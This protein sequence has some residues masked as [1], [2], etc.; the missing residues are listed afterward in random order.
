M[1]DDKTK[2]LIEKLE[3]GVMDL[4]SSDKY[5]G[6]LKTMS[7]FYNYSY[8]NSLLIALQNPS[9]TYVAGFNSWRNN[10]KRSVN[11]GEK[12][13]PIL[14]PAPF[15]TT[16]E[17][18]KNDP[19]TKK[20]V[21]DKDGKPVTEM[22][23]VTK[24]YFKA[25]YVF[26]VS[27][28]SGEPLPSI[29]DEI[30]ANV[31]NFKTFYKSLE[32]VSPF[33]IEIQDIASEAKGYYDP[34]N[35]KIVIR[36]GMSE[37]QTIKT[38]LHEVAHSILHANEINDSKDNR[39]M[40]V[41]AESVAFV[42]SNH[43]GIDTS[44]Y[45]FGYIAS[46]SSGMELKELKNSL[47]T[48]QKTSN[49]LINEIETAFKE[50]QISNQN[51]QDTTINEPVSV[52]TANSFMDSEKLDNV[53]SFDKYKR[54]SDL[55]PAIAPVVTFLW[56]EHDSIKDNQ[57]MSLHDA[58]SLMEK[59]DARVVAFK[60]EA[61]EKGDYYPYFKT[62]FKIDF[63]MN[64]EI[65]TYKGRQDIGDGDGSLIN[66][67]KDFGEKE[68]PLLQKA[69]VIKEDEFKVQS[70]L[71]KELTLYLEMHNNL[72]VLQNTSVDQMK[73]IRPNDPQYKGYVEYYKALSE[74]INKS[75]HELNHS[76]GYNPPATP[77]RNDFIKTSLLDKI[78][79]AKSRSINDNQIKKDV[80]ERG[81]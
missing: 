32:K 13:I 50:L 75:R 56:S 12:G 71:Y 39:T 5:T 80:I 30:K 18:Q 64:G 63:M 29:A 38:C 69:N 33:P 20:Q 25:V 66:H 27:Q 40:E 70:A 17:M 46:W 58:S 41:E 73:S 49:K 77:D 59:L 8:N 55:D 68:L 53:I 16:I 21:L 6:Y 74:F 28:T 65:S 72:E 44:E 43:F 47:D 48:I 26:D 51:V 4:Y 23:E 22:V 9:A 45:S 67:I 62:S 57:K 79:E 36:T 2:E 52:S 42:V 35:Q 78:N 31:E 15:K 24:P 60:Q 7:K 1:K 54:N 3:Q 76:S 10:F 11:K 19:I 81:R 14:A 34:V 37:A 61:A